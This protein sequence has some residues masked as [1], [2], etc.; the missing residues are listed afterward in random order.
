MNNLAGESAVSFFYHL[1]LRFMQN[2][3]VAGIRPRIDF[4][5]VDVLAGSNKI[6]KQLEDL[7]NEKLSAHSQETSI[8]GNDETLTIKY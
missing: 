6:I 1:V 4:F 5:M 8:L 2:T 3:P 7:V